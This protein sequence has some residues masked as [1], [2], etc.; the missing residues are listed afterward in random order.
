MRLREFLAG[1]EYCSS[2]WPTLTNETIP[3]IVP[4]GTAVQVVLDRSPQA[5]RILTSS[6]TTA[7]SSN[8]GRGAGGQSCRRDNEHR[9]ENQPESHDLN[10]GRP[11]ENV[12]TGS[13]TQYFSSFGEEMG[14]WHLVYAYLPRLSFCYRIHDEVIQFSLLHNEFETQ[15][16]SYSGNYRS[17]LI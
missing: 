7:I 2:V 3:L 6:S 4:E 5:V 10:N 15:L 17:R 14:H 11:R 8:V 1:A 16:F 9:A 12:A 13:R